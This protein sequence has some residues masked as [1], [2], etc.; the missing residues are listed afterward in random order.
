VFGFGFGE[1]ASAVGR[2]AAACRQLAVRARRHMDT[3]VA[4]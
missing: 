1:V 2:S 4:E 3:G